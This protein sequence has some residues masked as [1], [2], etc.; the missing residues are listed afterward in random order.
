M[1]KSRKEQ[2]ARL[3]NDGT[4][5]GHGGGGND[6]I[7]LVLNMFLAKIYN[8]GFFWGGGPWGDMYV[9]TNIFTILG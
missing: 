8:C 4:G 9:F 7:R 6:P 2:K 3:E 1:I 5:R